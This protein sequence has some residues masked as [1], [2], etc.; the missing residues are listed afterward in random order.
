VA[1]QACQICGQ[2]SKPDNM[3]QHHIVPTEVTA[4]SG[5]PASQILSVCANCHHEVHSWYRSK[6]A[7]TTYDL[8]LK[9]FRPRSDLELVREYQAA[10][11]SFL[12]YKAEQGHRTVPR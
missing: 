1:R 2:H 12:K 7:R 10:F 6:V 3:E 11:D 4:P 8:N 5:I 9:R